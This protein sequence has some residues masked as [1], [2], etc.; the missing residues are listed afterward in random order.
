MYIH[1]A[2]K[3]AMLCLA[4][5]AGFATETRAMDWP[6]FFVQHQSKA[7]I[8]LAVWGLGISSLGL[9]SSAWTD[10]TTEVKKKFFGLLKNDHPELGLPPLL[11]TGIAHLLTHGLKSQGYTDRKILGGVQALG[12]LA[13]GVFGYKRYQDNKKNK[14]TLAN[15]VYSIAFLNQGLATYKAFN[16]LL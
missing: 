2:M 13:H 8:S 12:L 15:V 14:N 4:F 6:S 1:N 10:R 7:T 5:G 3:K 16:G 9:A 11:A